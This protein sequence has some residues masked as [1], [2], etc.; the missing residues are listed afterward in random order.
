MSNSKKN[1]KNRKNLRRKK[2]NF[3][4]VLVDIFPWSGDRGL[5]KLRKTMFL[6]SI[7]VF[8][9]CLFLVVD[10]FSEN[11]KSENLYDDLQKL[12]QKSDSEDESPDTPSENPNEPWRQLLVPLEGA[13]ALLA[14]NPDTVG[15]LSIDGTKISYPLLWRSVDDNFYLEHNFYG[16]PAKLGAIFLD[17]RCD[18]DV[19]DENNMRARSN[20]NNLVIYGHNAKDFSM[21]GQLKQYD[22]DPSF[23]GKHPIINLNSNYKMYKYKIF[24]VCFMNDKPSQ[25]D[26]YDY[27]NKLSFSTK[28]DFYSFANELKKRSIITNE[29][30]LKFGDQF[31]TL[32]TCSSI[33]SDAKLIVVGRLV[34]EG[35]D[36]LAGTQNYS[37]NENVRMPDIWYKNHSGSFDESKFVPYPTR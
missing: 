16:E 28:E 34:R 9:V 19:V 20:T 25:G 22:K 35:E 24:A 30:D 23:Y 15:Y 27:Q 32:S 3:T 10:Y 21:F 8:A 33:F 17:T 31:V 18:F 5:E 6:V 4:D 11:K 37:R 29:V 36:I 1:Q 14:H 26:V 12:Y 13:Q 7:I 2:F